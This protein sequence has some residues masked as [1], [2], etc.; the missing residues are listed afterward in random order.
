M[1]GKLL[2]MTRCKVLRLG[3]KSADSR[4]TV[5][6][7]HRA[8]YILFRYLYI[9]MN[10]YVVD[11]NCSLLSSHRVQELKK[12]NKRRSILALE[13][14]C[15]VPTYLE[16]KHQTGFRGNAN[17][18]VDTGGIERCDYNRLTGKRKRSEC[19]ISEQ[20][21]DVQDISERISN[22][23]HDAQLHGVAPDVAPYMLQVVNV[24]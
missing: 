3:S 14:R 23:V 9:L 10:V 5:L 22:I 17:N 15:D 7:T 18:M 11:I 24:S 2:E 19:A 21:P 13:G 16:R 6:N 20:M 8:K 4:A 12:V 1:I